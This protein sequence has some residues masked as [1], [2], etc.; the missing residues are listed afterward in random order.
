MMRKATNQNSQKILKKNVFSN[1]YQVGQSFHVLDGG[2][3]LL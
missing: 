2:A 3:L 1:S